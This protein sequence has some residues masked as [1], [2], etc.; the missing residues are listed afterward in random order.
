VTEREPGRIE[1]MSTQR[2][3][4]RWQRTRCMACAGA[5]APIAQEGCAEPGSSATGLGRRGG[6]ASGGT[7]PPGDRVSFHPSDKDP[8]LGAAARLATNSLQSDHRHADSCIDGLT[9]IVRLEIRFGPFPI[10]ARRASTRTPEP[11]RL[12]PSPNLLP[13]RFHLPLPEIPAGERRRAERY[14]G[15][16]DMHLLNA[17]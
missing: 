13:T 7:A 1:L 9:R 5:W 11:L 14:D 6:D 2:R 16:R 8:S 4:T 15:K 17:A 12:T 10:K 3:E